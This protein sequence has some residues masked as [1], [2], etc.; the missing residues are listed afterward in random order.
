MSR[1]VQ[2]YTKLRALMEREFSSVAVPDSPYE[3]IDTHQ[4][5]QASF[6]GISSGHYSELLRGAKLLKKS[7]ARRMAQKLR[8]TEAEQVVL[9]KELLEASGA[10]LPVTTSASDVMTDKEL[11]ATLHVSVADLKRAVRKKQVPGV[12]QIG[13]QLRFL[14]PAIN[15][16]LE[17]IARDEGSG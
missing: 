8:R 13:D 10:A 17:R 3:D 5:E 11:A 7:V 2:P 6:L 9:V 16:W 1:A 14:R 4:N 12:F 15:A